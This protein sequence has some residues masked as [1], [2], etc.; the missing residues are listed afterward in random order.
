MDV[1]DLSQNHVEFALRSI[2]EIASCAAQLKLGA[3]G[4]ASCTTL[5]YLD[6]S[7][8]WSVLL[9][10]DIKEKSAAQSVPFEFFTIR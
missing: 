7:S 2:T 1:I 5:L 3:V 10:Y 4:I 8:E 9:N 6:S